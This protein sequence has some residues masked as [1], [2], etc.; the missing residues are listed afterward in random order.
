MVA[1]FLL[2]TLHLIFDQAIAKDYFPGGH[3]ECRD[4]KNLLKH[5][6]LQATFHGIDTKLTKDRFQGN[7]VVIRTWRI[8]GKSGKHLFHFKL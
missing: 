7:K 6:F 3:T 4:K 8:V 2:G 1:T 5:F